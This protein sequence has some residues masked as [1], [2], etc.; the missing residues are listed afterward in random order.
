LDGEQRN[1]RYAQ[2]GVPPTTKAAM[3]AF[4]RTVAQIAS[5]RYERGVIE[6]LAARR[7]DYF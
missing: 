6:I 1:E 2:Q 3:M 5:P 4:V 7:N